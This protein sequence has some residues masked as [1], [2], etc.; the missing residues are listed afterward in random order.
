MEN[1]FFGKIIDTHAHVYPNKIAERAVHAIGDFYDISMKEGGTVEGLIKNGEEAGISRFVI[2]SL[3]TTVHQVESINNFIL[4]SQSEHSCFIPF[5]T[6]HP[7]MSEDEIKREV[8]RVIPLGVK[9]VKLHPDFQ[10]FYIDDENVFKIYRTVKG[11]LPILFHVGDNRY[12]Y[13]APARLANVCRL[14][15]DLEVIAAHFGGYRRWHEIDVYK[16]LDNVYF[17][18]CSSFFVLSKT[19]A[20]DI[21]HKLG[22]E[23]FFFATDYPMWS[24]KDEVENI[25]N[26]DI[27][28]EE[29]EM[30]FYKNTE[31]VL[32]L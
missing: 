32:G 4:S 1:K 31:R 12:E 30:I 17:D 27:T 28:D 26:L 23:K 8:D 21:I 5:M 11:R 10:K 22:V 19:E 14:F 6:L 3:A 29:K 9:G 20:C 7:D 16:G 13:S 15:P 2:H 18:T 24:A 25:L